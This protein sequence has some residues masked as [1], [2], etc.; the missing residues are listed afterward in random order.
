MQLFQ[1]LFNLFS[2]T[3]LLGT[4][5]FVGCEES[6]E[7]TTYPTALETAASVVTTELNATMA[8]SPSTLKSINRNIATIL[9]TDIQTQNEKEATTFTKETQYCDISGIKESTNEGTLEKIT[10]IQK[11]NACKNAQY[12]QNGHLTIDYDEMNNEGKFPKVVK[13]IVEDDFTFND[14][15]LKKGTVITSNIEYNADNSIKSI[16]LTSNGVIMYQYGTYGLVN[17]SDTVNF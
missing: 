3:M 16:S 4:L 5:L 11:F 8:P 15:L 2:L 17:D 9:K 10:K 14:I 7:T 13:L 1:K 12:L 6:E